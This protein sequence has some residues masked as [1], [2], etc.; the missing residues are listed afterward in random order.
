MENILNHGFLELCISKHSLCSGFTVTY[1]S[2]TKMKLGDCTRNN[3][4]AVFYE[5]CSTIS[6]SLVVVFLPP[7]PVQCLSLSERSHLT[8][9]CPPVLLFLEDKAQMFIRSLNLRQN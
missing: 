3:R 9:C 2:T 5:A 6:K 4:L 1:I 8:S 7:A